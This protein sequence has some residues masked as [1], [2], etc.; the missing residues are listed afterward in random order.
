MAKE[1]IVLR[2]N[3]YLSKIA[4]GV[5]GAMRHIGNVPEFEIAIETSVI[6]H[7]ES[8]TVH[9]TTDLVLYDAIKVTFSGKL[10]EINKENLAYILSG[11][12]HTVASKVVTDQDL[13]TVVANQEIKLDGYNLSAVTIK[14]ST[15]GTPVTVNSSKIKLDQKFGTIIIT[16][17]T[18]L[19][20]PLKAAYTTGEVTNT[21]FASD[22]DAEYALFFKGTNKRGGEH[23]ALNLWRTTK[24][25]EATFPLIHGNEFG[26]YDIQGTALSVIEN[27]ADPKLGYFGHLVT[28]PAAA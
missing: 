27:E 11:E 9:N 16:D 25:P 6:E 22:L 20:M 2:G 7:Q 19:T 15:S 12:N 21:T 24:S 3:F 13:G 10:E 1:Y 17:V 8:M 23:M 4:N 28:I 14:D 26:Q 5:A 18:G